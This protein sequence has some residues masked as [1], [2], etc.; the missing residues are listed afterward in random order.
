MQAPFFRR[1]GCADQEAGTAPGGKKPGRG[2]GA[3]AHKL[4]LRPPGGSQDPPLQSAAEPRARSSSWLRS[5]G[6]AFP[7]VT[8]ITCPTR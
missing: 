1:N 8:R 5:W 6:L 4:G 2:D 7:L 3:G